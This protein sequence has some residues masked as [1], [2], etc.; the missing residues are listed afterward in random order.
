MGTT[1]RSYQ[2]AGAGHYKQ[3]FR[4]GKLKQ[5]R[6]QAASLGFDLTQ[7]PVSIASIED[8]S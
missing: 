3:Q 5:L 1:R 6:K 2:D 7:Q 4:Q 8:V